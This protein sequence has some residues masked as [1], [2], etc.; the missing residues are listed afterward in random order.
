MS[1]SFLPVFLFLLFTASGH[2]AKQN[3]WIVEKHTGYRLLYTETDKKNIDEYLPF[4]ENGIRSVQYF[5][6]AEFKNEFEIFI[7]PDRFSLDNQWAKDW[8]VP[9]FKSEC[10]MV[11]SGVANKLDIISPKYWDKESCEHSYNNTTR[12]QQV[13]IHELVHVFHG[14]LN[15]SPDFSDVSG[16]DWFI[17]GLATFASGQCDETR[18]NEIRKALSE[19]EIPRSLDSFWTGKLRYGLS[20]SIVMYIDSKYGRARLKELL[21]FSRKSELLV[22]LGI[23]EANLLTGWEQFIKTL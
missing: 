20:G 16:I 12:T 10:W 22:S 19:N 3:N 1:K 11:A 2:P 14:Q 13:I 18:I 6:D 23:T 4:I 5:F 9:D 21:K 15:I 7:H 8:H 17:E